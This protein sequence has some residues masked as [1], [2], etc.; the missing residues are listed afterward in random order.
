MSA[1]PVEDNLSMFTGGDSDWLPSANSYKESTFELIPP[2]EYE[3]QLVEVSETIDGT[4]GPYVKAVYELTDGEFQG[5]RLSTIVGLDPVDMSPQR[6]L[7]NYGDLFDGVVWHSKPDPEGKVWARLGILIPEGAY[8]FEITEVGPQ[9]PTMNQ[10]NPKQVRRKITFEVVGDAAGNPSDWDGTTL[11]RNYTWTM[12]D[13]GNLFPLMKAAVG[14]TFDPDKRYGPNDLV[15][16]RVFNNIVHNKG[17]NG[18]IYA[19]LGNSPWAPPKTRQPKVKSP[20]AVVNTDGP[21]P[22]VG[23]TDTVPF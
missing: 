7:G 11:T 15:G 8:L 6:P 14:G 10:K 18:G 3:V 9:E 4:Y 12:F 1:D 22:V 17:S 16:Q 19:N 5:Q 20:V 23:I 2:G 21:I 13:Q